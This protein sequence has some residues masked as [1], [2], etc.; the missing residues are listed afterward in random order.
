MK[1]YSN[2][3]IFCFL[4]LLFLQHTLIPIN[5]CYIGFSLNSISITIPERKPGSKFILDLGK[6]TA[7]ARVK[8]N[9]KYAGGV[10][11]SSCQ[12]VIT[13]F[14]EAGIN[15]LEISVVNTWMNRLIGNLKLP[16]DKRPTWSL[17]IP[18]KSDSPLQPS[19]LFGP[20]KIKEINNI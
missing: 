20:V 7:M 5:K 9:G 17:V 2:T 12:L 14:L 16:V 6:L 10:W 1:S 4:F 19:G 11:T 13:P 15:D 3:I 18:Y 8:V